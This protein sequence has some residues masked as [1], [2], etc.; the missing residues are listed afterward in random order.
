MNS[1]RTVPAIWID[2]SPRKPPDQMLYPLCTFAPAGLP[3]SSTF[4]VALLSNALSLAPSLGAFSTVHLNLRT[5]ANSMR[6][7]RKLCFAICNW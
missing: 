1:G 2:F 5:A 4:A 3:S 6:S 7:D